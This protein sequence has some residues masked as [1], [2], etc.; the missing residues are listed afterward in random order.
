MV[1]LAQGWGGARVPEP[2]TLQAIAIPDK[3]FHIVGTDQHV[4]TRPSNLRTLNFKVEV[5]A[6]RFKTS[7]VTD[8]LAVPDVSDQAAGEG[9]VLFVTTDGLQ[10]LHAPEDITVQ[11]SA[12]GSILTYW[13]SK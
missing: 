13:W 11:G 8:E 2:E 12:A 5:D 7:L 9:S 6:F 1:D 10:H 4:I 3:V